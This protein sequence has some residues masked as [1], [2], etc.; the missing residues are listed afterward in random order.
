MFK[1]DTR[2]G[3]DIPSLPPKNRYG[4]SYPKPEGKGS[5][6]SYLKEKSLAT[7]LS[8]GQSVDEAGL[9]VFC[10][11]VQLTENADTDEGIKKVAGQLDCV[12]FRKIF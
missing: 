7:E 10:V 1:E 5:A 8:A 6:L 4:S 11:D 9:C 3:K 12:D 2:K